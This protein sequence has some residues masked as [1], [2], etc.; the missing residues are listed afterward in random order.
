MQLRLPQAKDVLKKR[1]LLRTD[2]NVPIKKIGNHVA[3]VDDTRIKRSLK[4]LRFLIE[5]ESTVIIA[6]H[7]GRPNGKFEPDFSTKPIA[8]SLETIINQSVIFC[9][10]LD[11]DKVKTCIKNAPKKSVIMLEN[12]RFFPEEET[13]KT[14]FA[15]QL[16]TLADIYVNEAFSTAHRKHASIV[17]LPKCLPAYAGFGFNEEVSELYKLISQPKRP[18]VT[19]VGGAKI[20]DKV[21]AVKH[22]TQIAN[23]VLVGGGAANNFLAAEGYDTASSYLQEKTAVNGKNG[24][25]VHFAKNL[26]SK[27]KRERFL[28][29]GYIPLPKIIYPTDV[30]AADELKAKEGYVV[31]LYGANGNKRVTDKLMYLDIGP[32]TIKLYKEIILSA[33]TVFWNGPMGVFENPTFADGTR[34]IAQAIAKTPAYTV[35]GGGD[36]LAAVDAF[37]LEGR[38]DY[39]SAAGGAAL[40]FLAGKML[41]GVRPLVEKR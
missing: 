32:K 13:N 6:T 40:D 37:G 10:E 3:V 31:Q 38:F 25:Y 34:E 18:F 23:I 21:A 36:T 9:G 29:D 16:A 20:S 26:I 7:L 30:I 24:N 33:G 27:T 41:P 17:G 5:Q 1:V 22:L 11:I 19:V 2:Y 4:T 15:K 39:V 35:I 28:K 8:K 14:E 12:L